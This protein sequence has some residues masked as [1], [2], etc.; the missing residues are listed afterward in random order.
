MA[1]S[2]ISVLLVKTV[3]Y[4]KVIFFFRLAIG[5]GVCNIPFRR[6]EPGQCSILK[7]LNRLTLKDQ[8]TEFT[9]NRSRNLEG[10]KIHLWSYTINSPD[11]VFLSKE[12]LLIPRIKGPALLL[13]ESLK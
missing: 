6:A 10:R 8:K 3:L 11:E 2:Y 12:E 9:G 1:L 7:S 13:L 4:L 5:K